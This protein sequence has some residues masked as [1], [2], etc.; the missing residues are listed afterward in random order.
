M[1]AVSN[2]QKR[3]EEISFAIAR[4]KDVLRDLEKSKSDAQSD[5]NA[6]LDPMARLPLE[7]SS[8]IFT[9]CLPNNIIPKPNPHEVP[10]LFTNVC[11]SWNKIAISTPSLWAAIRIE[12]PSP[13]CIGELLDVWLHRARNHALNI[14]LSGAPAPHV[15]ASVLQYAHQVETLYLYFSSGDDLED[16]TKPLPSLKTLI[17]GKCPADDEDSDEEFP[18][19][20]QYSRTATECIHILA[21]APALVACTFERIYCESDLDNTVDYGVEP[22]LTHSTSN[23]CDWA[24]TLTIPA[25]PPFSNIS[26]SPPWKAYVSRTLALVMMISYNFSPDLPRRSQCW[27]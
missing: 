19:P 20:K 23:I 5:L 6:I 22:E 24:K 17:I 11:R 21:A 13:D 3:I 16:I 9:L 14:S 2:L 12:E 10:M 27:R 1:T 25:A 18:G 26:H 7:I 15:R 8:S 4:Q